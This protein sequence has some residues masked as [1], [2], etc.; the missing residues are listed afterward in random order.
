MPT[1]VGIDEAGYGPMFGPMTIG[2]VALRTPEPMADADPAH[3]FWD[4]LNAGVCKAP[5]DRRRR[6][7]V[8]DSKKLYTP[9]SKAG[10]SHL[11]R[12]TLAF[13]GLTRERIG[14]VGVL[15]DHLEEQS[16]RDAS[17]PDWY[18]P[19]SESDAGPWTELPTT[20]TGNQL[21]I[22]VSML[23]SAMQ[24]AGV[25]LAGHRVATVFEPRFNRMVRATRSKASVSFTFVAGHLRTAW[26]RWGDEKARQTSGAE[27]SGG[28]GGGGGGTSGGGVIATVDRQSGRSH[29][30]ELLS[31]S[32]PEATVQVIEEGKDASVYLLRDD[33]SNRTM[34][35]AF[36]VKADDTH[37]TVALASMM[38]K[39]VRQLLMQRMQA[40]FAQRLPEVKPTQGYGAD[41]KRFWRDIQPRLAELSI[42]PDAIRREA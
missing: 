20:M 16:H 35:V 5:N 22:E 23:R 32:F 29:Y 10:I 3:N 25:E 12:S 33:D 30:R 26:E 28:G 37:L 1:Y 18:R 42:A 15:L 36:E 31:Q 9:K 27:T 4:R 39:Y 6:L 14:D 2:A 13:L 41:G 24:A 21:L 34:R 11:E 17:L 8:A 7:P 19:G 40:W 38:S